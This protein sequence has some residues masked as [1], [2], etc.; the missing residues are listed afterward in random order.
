MFMLKK[1]KP[2][3][4]RKKQMIAAAWDLSKVAVIFISI[5]AASVLLNKQDY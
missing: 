2:Q 4:D 3:V 1:K 5:R